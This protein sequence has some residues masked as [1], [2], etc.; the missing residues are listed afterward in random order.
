MTYTAHA[1]TVQFRR[2]TGSN[3]PVRRSLFVFPP[4]LPRPAANLTPFSRPRSINFSV[5]RA[6][7]RSRRTT[8]CTT[9]II[10]STLYR[11][12]VCIVCVRRIHDERSHDSVWWNDVLW[13]AAYYITASVS[14]SRPKV[15]FVS[16]ENN[17]TSWARA[18]VRSLSH[19]VAAR[20]TARG[21]RQTQRWR[22]GGNHVFFPT[23]RPGGLFIIFF[24]EHKTRRGPQ[25]FVSRKWG[26]VMSDGRRYRFG[27]RIIR[28]TAIP[29]FFQSHRAKDLA[30]KRT[31]CVGE[32]NV[33]SSSF[34]L[35]VLI[36]FSP[37]LF[38]IMFNEFDK[39]IEGTSAK[40]VRYRYLKLYRG[41]SLVIIWAYLLPPEIFISGQKRFK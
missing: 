35:H 40:F 27:S 34:F 26:W 30:N 13:L 15:L 5:I 25:E 21:R 39:R 4:P 1:W 23:K 2:L 36:T 29:T 11:V 20:P 10:R 41:P 28:C 32:K 6:R 31:K 19:C 37:P 9:D 17:T 33:I 22:D 16:P 24:S 8:L 38:T 14:A 12:Y 3:G 18:R 7:A